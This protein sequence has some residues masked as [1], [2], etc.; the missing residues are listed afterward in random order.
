MYGRLAALPDEAEP[1]QRGQLIAALSVGT[2]IIHLRQT[3]PRLGLA[4]QLDVALEAFAQGNSAIAIARL[5]QLDRRLAS[6]PEARPETTIALRA[7]G[8]ILAISNALAEHAPYF[9]AGAAA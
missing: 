8:H 1:L 9:D 5:S 2:E 3:A 4:A 6:R 7:R